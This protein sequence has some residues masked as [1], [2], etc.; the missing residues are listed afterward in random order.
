MVAEVLNCD[1]TM[2]GCGYGGSG[3]LNGGG[4][5]VYGRGCV[6]K[7]LQDGGGTMALPAG[8]HSITGYG[9]PICRRINNKRVVSG[10][11]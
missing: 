7:V 9:Y 5:E 1:G 10:V 11:K 4:G 2:A 6:A 3:G 8:H